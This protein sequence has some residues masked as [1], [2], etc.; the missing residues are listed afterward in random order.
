MENNDVFDLRDISIRLPERYAY[1]LP[2]VLD[3]LEQHNSSLLDTMQ[4]RIACAWRYFDW[5]IPFG[6]A[7][8]AFLCSLRRKLMGH[9]HLIPKMDWDS[10]TLHCGE[11]VEPAARSD[12][13]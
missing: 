5:T 11:T 4:R 6:R 10:C 9:Q 7:G 2:D 12:A 8:E 3:F 1:K 13:P